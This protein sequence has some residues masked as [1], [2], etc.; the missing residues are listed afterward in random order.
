ML[1]NLPDKASCLCDL[2]DCIKAQI[3]E[4]E[5][6][7][8]LLGERLGH[9]P[10]QD[11]TLNEIYCEWIQKYSAS[12]RTWWEDGRHTQAFSV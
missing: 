3:A 6:F 12:F 10:L 5:R 1:T 4:M 11:R 2:Q 9:D 7:K 8:W